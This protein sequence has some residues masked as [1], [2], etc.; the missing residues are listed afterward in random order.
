MILNPAV[1]A[2]FVSSILIGLLLAF[3]S[4]WAAVI[5]WSWDLRSGSELQLALERRTYLISTVLN[6]V[7][8]FQLLS[9]FLF[10]FTADKLCTMF[11]GAMC[12]AGSLNADA[13]GYPTLLLKIV[14]FL[15]AGTWL[16]LNHADAR[17]YDYPLLRA[18]YALL[19]ALTPLVLAEVYLQARY[20]LGLRP[21]LITSCCG[22]LFSADGKTLAADLASLPLGPTRLAFFG[23]VAATLAAGAYHVRTGRGTYLFSLLSLWTFAVSVAALISFVSIYVYEM[24][25]H[26][27]PFCVLQPDYHYVGY[28]LYLSLLGGAVGGAGVGALAPFG[29]VPSLRAYLPTLQRRLTVLSCLCYGGFAALAIEQMVFSPFRP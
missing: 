9:L 23:S 6:C 14:N 15:L 16:V 5:V 19:F 2:L 1:L 18:K 10:I 8:T 22:S 13:F 12:A 17:A 3:S 26:H 4:Y 7:F 24:P 11:A 21:D 25:T 20:F 27:C 28:L 29:G